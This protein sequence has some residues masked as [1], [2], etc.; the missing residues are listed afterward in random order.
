MLSE[1]YD[2]CTE[3]RFAVGCCLC[4]TVSFI[5]LL[6]GIVISVQENE[7]GLFV[8]LCIV[9]FLILFCC[10]VACYKGL[11]IPERGQRRQTTPMT[12]VE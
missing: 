10:I 2:D 1:E 7:W 4:S 8:I 12:Q 9:F 11:T 5:G 6:I 3:W